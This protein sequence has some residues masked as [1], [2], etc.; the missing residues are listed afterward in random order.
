MPLPGLSNFN[1]GILEHTFKASKETPD[2]DWPELKPQALETP[3]ANT[4]LFET[5]PYHNGSLDD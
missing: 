3:D 4:G 5:S 2:S 1:F